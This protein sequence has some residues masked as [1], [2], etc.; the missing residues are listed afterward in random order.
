MYEEEFVEEYDYYA[1]RPSDLYRLDA[2][3]KWEIS[4]GGPDIRGWSVIDRDG[5]VIGAV[6]DLLVS[7]EAGQAIFAIVSHRTAAG[8]TNHARH[9][10]PL[11]RL[12]T[13]EHN[14]RVIFQGTIDQAM[15]VPEYTGSTGDYTP[16]YDYWAG[17]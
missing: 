9:L 4:G 5:C 13:D 1:A 17:L 6:E 12:E 7:L 8:R 14:K 11:S 3:G 15:N 2:L 16:F 10:I